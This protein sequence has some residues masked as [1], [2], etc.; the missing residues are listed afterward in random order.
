MICP[1]CGT[2]NAAGDAFCGGCGAFLEFATE[3]AGAPEVA[4]VP[5]QAPTDPVVATPVTGAAPSPGSVPPSQ[6]P[7]PAAAPSSAAAPPPVG[8]EMPSLATTGPLCPICGRAN[9]AGRTFCISCGERLPVPGRA[10]AASA[11]TAAPVPSAA[12]PP[13]AAPAP[14][15]APGPATTAPAPVAATPT[16]R[17]ATSS[18]A[19]PPPAVGPVASPPATGPTWEFPS[20][21]TRPVTAPSAKPEATA[22]ASRRGRNPL[23]LVV[24]VGILFLVLAGGGAA[25]LLGGGA[26]KATPAPPGAS[27]SAPTSASAGAVLPSASAA[28]PSAAAAS[29]GPSAAAATL[30][31]GPAIALTLTGAS[32]SSSLANH[33]P[34]AAIDGDP[35][36]SWKT[37]TKS[38]SDQWLEVTFAPAA[39]TQIQL[40]NGW[41]RTQDIYLGNDRPRNVTIRFDNEIAIPLKLLDVEG[42]Q[43]VDIPPQLGVVGVTRLRIAIVDWYPAKKTAAT[44]SPTTQAPISEIRLFGIPVTP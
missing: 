3:E 18:G 14:T 9:P 24:G 7:A 31:P 29:P 22:P 17:P 5:E 13:T 10:G 23:S 19:V 1:K 41:Q 32:A 37:G 30:P 21:P 20:G 11:R 6:L 34:S 2:Q 26:S 8:S 4:A 35:T 12:R 44:G 43:R 40:W 33:P 27:P 15:A 42:F 36:T 28:T 16:A 38:P 39:V 25:I